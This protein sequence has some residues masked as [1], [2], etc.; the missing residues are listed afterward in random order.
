MRRRPSP[1]LVVSI[2]AVVFA[3]AGTS[4]AAVSFARNAGAVDGKSAT[5]A[6]SSNQRAAGKLVA[7]GPSGRLPAR[8]LDLSGA[9]H[10]GSSTFEQGTDVVD[11]GETNPV[12]VGGIT[13]LGLLAATCKDQNAKAGV[14][15]PQ[16]TLTWANTA[17]DAVNYDRTIGGG[18]PSVIALAAGAQEPFTIQN[19]NTF[20]IHVERH[21]KS[22]V[23]DGAF[24]QDGKGGSS[25]RCVV[26]AYALS[27]G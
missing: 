16:V 10:G 14:E 19:S 22:Y 25:G 17:G 21:G 1:S 26:Y 18:N 24:R 9:V 12:P 27:L 20:L 7:T 13:G 4:I 15:D 2:I 5:G 23:I 6:G 11:N 3:A 8:F